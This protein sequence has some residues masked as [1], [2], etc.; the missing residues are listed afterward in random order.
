MKA[1]AGESRAEVREGSATQA[2]LAR[3]RMSSAAERHDPPLDTGSNTV[4]SIS[5]SPRLI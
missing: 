3:V 4:L 5:Y 1:G 2:S